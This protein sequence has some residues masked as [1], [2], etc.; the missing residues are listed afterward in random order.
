MVRKLTS[1][2]WWFDMFFTT[3]MTMIFIYLIKMIFGTVSV[4]VL[5]DVVSAV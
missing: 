1:L 2:S 3:L 5:S 4:P